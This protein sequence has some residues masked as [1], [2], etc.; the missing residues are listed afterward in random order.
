MLELGT[1]FED[2]AFIPEQKLWRAVLQRAFEDVIYPGME[3]PLIIHKYTAH[4]WFVSQSDDFNTVCALAGFDYE[5]VFHH[6]QGMIDR[7]QVYF[8]AEQLRY[9]NWRKVYNQKRKLTF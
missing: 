3:R 1:E 4:L 8:T 5:Y 6:Y 9:I 7:E 2:E